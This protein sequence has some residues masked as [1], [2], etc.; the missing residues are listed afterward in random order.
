MYLKPHKPP[1]D[2]ALTS[3]QERRLINDILTAI[4]IRKWYGC[5]K[6]CS[7][8]IYLCVRLRRIDDPTYGTLCCGCTRAE[9]DIAQ[10]LRA[11]DRLYAIDAL[12][13]LRQ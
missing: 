9:H 7:W 3:A 8:P 4:H 11:A 13:Y 6:L 5:C 12:E 1:N 2:R 10:R